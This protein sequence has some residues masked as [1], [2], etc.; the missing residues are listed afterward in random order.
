MD[1]SPLVLREL[2]TRL[3][4][5]DVGYSDITTLATVPPQARGHGRFLAKEALVLAGLEVALA[6]F[7]TV[8][9]TIRL[10][11]ALQ[12]GVQLTP[13]SVI[14]E[15]YGPARALLT[16]E[17][18]ALNLLQRLSGVATVTWRYV[19]SVRH[20]GARIIDT[21]K[22]TP[23]LRLLEKYAVRVGGGH[24]HRFGLGDGV[25]IKDNHIAIA[26]GITTAVHLARQTV[27]HLQKIEVEV[28]TF[29]QLHE[30]LAAGADAILL[31][32]MTPEQTREAVRLVRESPGGA[33]LLLESSGGITLQTAHLYAEAGVDLISV[34]ALTHSAPAVDISLEM[35]ADD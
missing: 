20:T 26:G 22:T 24:N 34:G 4:E 10:D 35:T 19:E 17:R 13:G 27:S 2:V 14:A 5:E 16:A 21:R 9:S 6:V 11:C 18:V 12:D 3:L 29:P 23:G 33:Q 25:L 7:H 15:I 8:D 30:A 32:N 1:L 31:D 28:E